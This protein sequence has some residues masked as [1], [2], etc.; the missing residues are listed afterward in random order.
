MSANDSVARP[1]AADANHTQ[2][3]SSE[4]DM[5]NRPPPAIESV[6]VIDIH[7]IHDA[8]SPSPPL[9]A[10]RSDLVESPS[11]Y[12]REWDEQPEDGKGKED[13]QEQALNEPQACLFVAR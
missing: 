3:K 4:S 8:H 9:P 2:T 12:A 1:R 10:S 5:E 13:D 11:S 7:T 6:K